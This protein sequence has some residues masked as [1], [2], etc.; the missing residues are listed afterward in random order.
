MVSMGRP[1]SGTDVVT[2]EALNDHETFV[3]R[4]P[5]VSVYVT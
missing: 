3:M 1:E 5:V 4:N 2:S